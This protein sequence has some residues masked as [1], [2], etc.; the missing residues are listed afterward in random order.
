MG[1][2]AV[3]EALARPDIPHDGSDYSE[4]R[5]ERAL[6]LEEIKF[7]R[8]VGEGDTPSTA[9]LDHE[10]VTPSTVVST[11]HDPLHLHAPGYHTQPPSSFPNQTVPHTSGRAMRSLMDQRGLFELPAQ[12]KP[13]PASASFHVIPPTPPLLSAIRSTDGYEEQET[14]E[15]H[16]STDIARIDSSAST[17]VLPGPSI[18]EPGPQ[19]PLSE[20]REE[21]IAAPPSPPA[22][23]S[24]S[25]PS[26]SPAQTADSQSSPPTSATSSAASPVQQTQS[27]Q[28]EPA[29]RVLVVDDDMLTRRLMSRMLTRLGCSVDTAENGKVALEKILHGSPPSGA[30][31]PGV[32]EHSG[33]P[34]FDLVQASSAA[35]QT[36]V[37]TQHWYN[38]DIVFLDNQMVRSSHI[39]FF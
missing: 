16:A 36:Q 13:R 2:K 30:P 19:A 33:P 3:A 25:P 20:V 24:T 34:M 31:T 11:E 6:G 29:L 32:S 14:S 5:R 12:A 9:V 26:S 27:T 17:R 7:F 1:E 23:H 15:E 22:I 18:S 10:G 37:S 35:T 38:Y 8:A 28:A 4:G 39:G 21:F